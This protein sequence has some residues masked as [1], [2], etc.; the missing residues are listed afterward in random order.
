MIP[1]RGDSNSR[2]ISSL[3]LFFHGAFWSS[4]IWVPLGTVAVAA[5]LVATKKAPVPVAVIIGS[6]VIVGSACGG[7]VC[8]VLGRSI[9]RGHRIAYFGAAAYL[10]FQAL[11]TGV[12]GALNKGNIFA[13]WGSRAVGILVLAV[14]VTIMACRQKQVD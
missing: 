12:I 5:Y 7:I 8:L 6:V 11:L 13:A 14:I 3:A 10:Y 9:L 1:T 2:L 4:V